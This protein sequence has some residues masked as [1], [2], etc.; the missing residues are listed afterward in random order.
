MRLILAGRLVAATALLL[1]AV[2]GVPGCAGVRQLAALRQVQFRFDRIADPQVA[3][4]S[5]SGIRSVED[6]NPFDLGRLTVAIAAGDVPL[7]LVVHVSARNPETNTTTARLRGLDW[8][9]LVDGREYV[10][11]EVS[12]AYEFPPGAAVDLPL[13]V[14]FNLADFFEKDSR[15]LLEAALAL[16]GQRASTHTMTLRLRPVIETPLGRMQYPQPI[17]LDLSKGER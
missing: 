10:N 7:D 12:E 9:Y 11:G 8:S 13:R 4:I 16:A 2:L 6:V 3:G 1:L 14:T 17:E 5:L 15:N